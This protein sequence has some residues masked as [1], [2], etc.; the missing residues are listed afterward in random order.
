MVK[1][2]AYSVVG[3]GSWV[4]AA[5]RGK[6]FP[7]QI[8]LQF[9]Q[10]DAFPTINLSGIDSPSGNILSTGTNA[11]FIEN[12]FIPSDTLTLVR[13]KHILRFGAEVMFAQDNSTPWGSIQPATLTFTG[14]FT[15]NSPNNLAVGYAAVF[16]GDVQTW[17][18]STQPQHGMRARN[19]SFFVQDAIK[20]C[21]NT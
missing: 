16:L 18:T 10:A 20:L 14:Q 8:G 5:T 1:V 6:G 13:G 3:W 19:P 2:L 4:V 11:V 15:S 9:A 12:T 7:G 21:A 17:N